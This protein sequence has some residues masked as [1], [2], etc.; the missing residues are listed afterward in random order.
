MS[1]AQAP[2]DLELGVASA[3]GDDPRAHEMR[4]RDGSLGHAA[5][6]APHEHRLA[7]PHARAGDEHPPRRQRRQ[8]ERRGLRPTHPVG[9][10]GDIRR[11]H[12]EELGGGPCAVLAEDPE[13]VAEGLVAGEAGVAA[14]AGDARVHHHAVARRKGGDARAHRLHGAGG[15]GSHDVRKDE[16][17]AGEAAGQHQV[18]P[19][20]C[21]RGDA[22]ADLV[23]MGDHRLGHI[24]DLERI[25]AARRRERERAHQ[26]DGVTGCSA[27][28]SGIGTAA[29]PE[30]GTS[31]RA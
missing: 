18:E 31:E 4:D 22:D 17:H 1:R 7:G 25:D 20:D 30:T 5:T 9:H 10:A 14:A 11:R 3:G 23:G 21:R 15:V 27:G 26:K 2:R 12:D 6:G 24:P 13:A 29:P 8:R 19:V 16:R 28:R